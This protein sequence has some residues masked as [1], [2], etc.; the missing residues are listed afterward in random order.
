M[1]RTLIPRE[2]LRDSMAEP[3]CGR[4]NRDV[5]GEQLPAIMAKDNQAIEQIE[6]DRRNSPPIIMGRVLIFRSGRMHRTGARSSASEISLHMQSWADYII[7]R[8]ESSFRKRQGA[9]L[10]R[11]WPLLGQLPEVL[12]KPTAMFCPLESSGE[13]R[14]KRFPLATHRTSGVNPSRAQ[15]DWV[16][17]GDGAR[18]GKEKAL[19]IWGADGRGGAAPCAPVRAIMCRIKHEI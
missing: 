3:R 18:R 17:S 16:C 19:P 7:G 9:K 14:I 11:K 5:E 15:V 8:H 12:Q 4:M 1:P 10:S 6:A 2:C 13:S